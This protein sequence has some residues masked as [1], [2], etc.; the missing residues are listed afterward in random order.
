MADSVC[1][2][3]T[4]AKP[5]LVLQLS[6]HRLAVV[7]TGSRSTEG[8]EPVAVED[9]GAEGVVDAVDDRYPAQ[10]VVVRPLVLVVRDQQ[11]AG[12]LGS[13]DDELVFEDLEEDVEEW[14]IALDILLVAD[15]SAYSLLVCRRGQ[16]ADVLGGPVFPR[17]FASVAPLFSWHTDTSEGNELI[18]SGLVHPEEKREA[19]APQKI[20]H[21]VSGWV[22][23]PETGL[24]R[25]DRCA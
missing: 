23:H 16:S 22:D 8:G 3:D 11:P 12:R 10:S 7:S 21:G 1:C 19:S 9:V 2:A 17:V 5:R 25:A 18:Y 4:T 24:Y 13:H 15:R 14:R 6:R 20:G